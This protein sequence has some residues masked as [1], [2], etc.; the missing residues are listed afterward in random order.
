ME[1][2]SEL[3]FPQ[4]DMIQSERRIQER[5]E[6]RFYQLVA[7]GTS[8]NHWQMSELMLQLQKSNHSAQSP[9]TAD[10]AA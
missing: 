1:G 7:E 4:V 9:Q 10:A 8:R 2:H 6:A 3:Q 5:A